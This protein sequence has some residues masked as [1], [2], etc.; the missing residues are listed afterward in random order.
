MEN[1]EVYNNWYKIA[2]V[3]N[4]YNY[5]EKIAKEVVSNEQ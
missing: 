4:V 1:V 5:F 3:K 2:S